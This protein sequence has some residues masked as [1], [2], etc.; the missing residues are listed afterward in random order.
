MESS[1]V[2]VGPDVS[3]EAGSPQGPGQTETTD[4]AMRLGLNRLRRRKIVMSSAILAISAGC[5]GLL[6]HF[7]VGTRSR[8]A[9]RP[10]LPAATGSQVLR[11]KGMT[12]AVEARAIQ[13]PLIAGQ[14]VGTLTIT[15]LIPVA[16]ASRRE[17]FWS[18]LTARRSCAISSISRPR[19]TT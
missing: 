4:S 6:F 11:L 15:K 9:A 19:P 3:G 10:A 5:V 8:T 17:I 2:E 18:S 7:F 16:R 12:A 13:A 1:P 14:Q